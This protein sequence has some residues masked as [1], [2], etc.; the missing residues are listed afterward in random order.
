MRKR[1]DVVGGDA[2]KG[3]EPK[4]GLSGSALRARIARK[5]ERVRALGGR[6]RVRRR[7]G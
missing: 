1:V 7:H 6:S 4:G 5:K 3:D 2:R